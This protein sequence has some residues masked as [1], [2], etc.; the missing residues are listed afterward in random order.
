MNIIH[1]LESREGTKSVWYKRKTNWADAYGW[2]DLVDD[3]PFQSSF[4]SF[5]DYET[6]AASQLSLS[7]LISPAPGF[8]FAC[9]LSLDRDIERGVSRFLLLASSNGVLALH[10]SWQFNPH[11]SA[12]LHRHAFPTSSS[13]YSYSSSSSSSFSSSSSW[14]HPP[15]T[16]RSSAIRSY[17]SPPPLRVSSPD[18]GHKGFV[19]AL[20]WFPFDSGMCFSGGIDGALLVW[21]ASRLVPAVSFRLGAAVLDAQMS[22]CPSPACG[23][24]LAVASAQPGMRL[25][26]LRT[27]NATHTLPGHPHP[28]SVVRWSPTDQH[29]LISGGPDGS[30]KIWDVRKG[31]RATCIAPP[32]TI[33]GTMENGISSSSSTS[34]SSNNNNNNNNN[35][36][37]SSFSSSSTV[38]RRR[39]LKRMAREH[40]AVLQHRA[41]AAAMA[42]RGGYGAAH[43]G[44]TY[45]LCWHPDGSRF[46]SAGSDRLLH[47]WS[48][49]R[50][51]L[52]AARY[53][54]G[55][56]GGA[57]GKECMATAYR[58]AC[59]FLTSGDA[60]RLLDFESG[61]E[62]AAPLEG[63]FAPAVACAFNNGL[64]ELYSIDK[65]GFA[66]VWRKQ[67]PGMLPLPSLDNQDAWS[68]GDDYS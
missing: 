9:A 52:A 51:E 28:L 4:P 1:R 21:D 6:R 26:D 57:L 44:E 46:L 64:D 15:A 13:S 23:S 19:H 50:G 11:A 27:G 39:K 38:V 53:P 42:S 59:L 41:P 22:P 5:S 63:H 56:V 17:R 7:N 40:E 31:C 36:S 37:I 60:I 16:E 29:C 55:L 12:S 49:E 34:T 8:S 3:L 35:T 66:V 10:D 54:F 65:E 33:L 45:A 32:S 68:D 47:R 67:P 62:I 18:Q 48:A 25:V 43:Y 2:G 20:S 61:Q 14:S 58:G 30:V 24:L